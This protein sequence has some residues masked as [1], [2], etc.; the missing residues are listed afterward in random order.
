MA[1]VATANLLMQF[2]SSSI[3]SC[4]YENAIFIKTNVFSSFYL[5][6]AG[7][8]GKSSFK[9]TQACTDIGL[10]KYMPI[11]DVRDRLIARWRIYADSE[12]AEKAL[13]IT[14]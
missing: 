6:L 9:I 2:L 11:A 10:R 14:S 3:N 5:K 7:F 13:N 1:I 8:L 12:E 4:Y